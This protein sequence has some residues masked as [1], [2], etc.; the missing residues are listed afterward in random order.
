[1]P[2]RTD[3]AF[4][5]ACVCFSCGYEL[6]PKE[7]EANWQKGSSA[8]DCD[9][10]HCG[11]SVEVMLRIIRFCDLAIEASVFYYDPRYL[12]WRLQKFKGKH[13][14]TDPALYWN[15]LNYY[16]STQAALRA[17]RRGILPEI[18]KAAA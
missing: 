12:L 10:P 4:R 1:M 3:F 7:L 9:C 6:S 2:N 5:V 16:P 17:A 13:F 18:N 15:T 14:R 11:H 8:V